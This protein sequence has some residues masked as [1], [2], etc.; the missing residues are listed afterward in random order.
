MCTCL[1]T[2]LPL[3]DRSKDETSDHC[4]NLSDILFQS[5]VSSLQQRYEQESKEDDGFLNVAN[6][7]DAAHASSKK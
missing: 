6:V 4:G 1:S 2:P 5:D 3:S 7:N